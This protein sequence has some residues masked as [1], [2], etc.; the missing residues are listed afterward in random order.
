MLLSLIKPFIKPWVVAYIVIY[1][2]SWIVP[3]TW[4]PSWV[5]YLLQ[6]TAF[7]YGAYHRRA[8]F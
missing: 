3:S 4:I 6:W 8:N 1:F 5:F 2:A 7:G